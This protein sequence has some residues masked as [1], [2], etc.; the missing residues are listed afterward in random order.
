MATENSTGTEQQADELMNLATELLT[1][2]QTRASSDVTSRIA[3]VMK[4]ARDD[5]AQPKAAELRPLHFTASNGIYGVLPGAKADDLQ[6][7]LSARAS[8]LAAMLNMAYGVG[9]ETFSAYGEKYQEGY[10]WACAS[11]AN[12]VEE[13]LGEVERKA[14]I[15]RRAAESAHG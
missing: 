5:A 13:L 15:E 6:A 7:H 4:A 1:A 2:A 11:L 8:Q 3:A 14:V 12:E 10:L 9:F